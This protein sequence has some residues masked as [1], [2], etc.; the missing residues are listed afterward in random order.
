M[1]GVARRVTLKGPARPESPGR[2]C[3]HDNTLVLMPSVALHHPTSF[4]N[5][6]PVNRIRRVERG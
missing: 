5:A 3:Y 1:L 2:G 6:S 4:S